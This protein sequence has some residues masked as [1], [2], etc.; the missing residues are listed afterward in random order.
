MSV[1]S[2]PSA[3]NPD[4]WWWNA[5]FFI[6]V[7]IAAILGVWL[8]PYYAVHRATLALAFALFQI[9]EISITVGYHRLYSHRSFRAA[10]SVRVF[11]AL[12]G[13]GAMQGSIKWWC[14]R[15]RLHHRF[16]DDPVHDPYAATRGLLWSHMGWIFFKPRYDRLK[17]IEQDDLRSDPVVRFQHKYYVPLALLIGFV[18]PPVAGWLWGD[19]YGAFVWGALVARVLIWHCTF[20]VNS[21]AHWDGLQPYSDENTSKSNLFLAMLTCGEG[22]HNFHHAF[23]HDYRSGPCPFD[24]DPSKWV[25]LSLHTLG[26]ATGLKRAR[27]DDVSEALIY[28]AHKHHAPLNSEPP[29]SSETSSE[30]EEMWKGAVWTWQEAAGYVRQGRGAGKCVLV[31]DGFAV[32]VTGYLGEHPGG[33][34]LLRKHSVRIGSDPTNADDKTWQEADWAFHGGYNIHTRAAHK[35]MRALRVAKISGLDI[36]K[37]RSSSI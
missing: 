20:F 21:L 12:M 19:P 1:P 37:D 36:A 31:I 3:A 32:D 35:R 27:P 18:L 26:L 28:M 17:V 30:D 24:W 13:A 29:H 5:G 6:S 34:T 14:L 10:R 4:V 7:H 22:N 8:Y 15:H 2:P 16:T 9:S 33:A 25:I 23:P 11:L